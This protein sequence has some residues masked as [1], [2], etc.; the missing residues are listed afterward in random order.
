VCLCAY[1]CLIYCIF[2]SSSSIVVVVV[3]SLLSITQAD[4]SIVLDPIAYVEHKESLDE[5]SNALKTTDGNIHL[6]I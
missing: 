5:L 4:L 2:T 1:I 3:A 6:S